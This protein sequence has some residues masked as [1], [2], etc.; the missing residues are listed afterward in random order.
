MLSLNDHDSMLVLS[1]H[2]IALS[3]SPYGWGACSFM[4]CVILLHISLLYPKEMV[5]GW[6][7]SV[8]DAF[9]LVV[10]SLG[11]KAII[12]ALG[13][14]HHNLSMTLFGALGGEHGGWLSCA[15]W[16]TTVMQ[17]NISIVYMTSGVLCCTSLLLESMNNQ[18]PLTNKMFVS[19]RPS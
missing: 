10:S 6:F 19:S 13:L 2:L 17:I 7:P 12:C 16:G 15:Q 8:N 18:W 4:V 3:T 9:C 5:T 1:G 11:S 14:L